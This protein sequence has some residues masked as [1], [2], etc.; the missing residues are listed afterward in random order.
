MSLITWTDKYSVGVE[1]IDAQHQQLI[2]IVNALHDALVA[3]SGKDS[4]GKILDE[5]V[6]YTAYHFDAEEKLMKLHGYDE[7]IKH[8]VKHKDLIRT[9]VELQSTVKTGATVLTLSAMDFLRYWLTHHILGSDM[10]LGRFL[11]AKGIH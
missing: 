3:G 6:D 10:P 9:A 2:A 1:E 5:L 7:H 11:N 4:L 8:V